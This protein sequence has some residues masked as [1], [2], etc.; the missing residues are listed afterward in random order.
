M[1][2]VE[3]FELER[4]SWQTNFKRSFQTIVKVS[5]QS[6][7]QSIISDQDRFKLFVCICESI[8]MQYGTS[9]SLYNS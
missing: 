5:Q 7:L 8:C 6:E 9:L 3:Q 4:L 1:Q 2:P